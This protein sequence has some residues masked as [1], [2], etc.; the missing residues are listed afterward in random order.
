MEAKMSYHRGSFSNYGLTVW[1][2]RGLEL[3]SY[4]NWNSFPL[5]LLTDFIIFTSYLAALS[6][7]FLLCKIG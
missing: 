4:L 6:S 7:S 2:S 1:A 3:P 5:K